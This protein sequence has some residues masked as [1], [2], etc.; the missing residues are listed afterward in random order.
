MRSKRG[1]SS[2][3]VLLL[4]AVAA[5]V[6]IACFS[7]L[8]VQYTPSALTRN[9]VVSFVYPEASARVVEAEVTSVIEGALSNIQY[10]KGVES[11]SR[12]G[13]GQII[14]RIGKKANME[15]V[16][17]DVAS[18]IRN[19]WTSL[20]STCTYPIV[21]TDS[22]SGNTSGSVM[23]LT[24]KSPLP[25]LQIA[26]FIQGTLIYPLSSIEGVDDVS[27]Y[28]DTPYEWVI[29]FDADKTQ[30]ADIS[31]VEISSA[32]SSYYG[33]VLVGMVSNGG[34]SFAVKLTEHTSDDFSAIPVKKV[35]GRIIHLGDIAQ[36]HYQESLPQS[37]YR[38]NGL[39]TL[40]LTVG[41]ASDANILS[42][43]SK[44]RDRLQELQ[45]AIPEEISIDISYDYSEYIS[46]ELNKIYQRTALCLLILLA[47]VFLA[48]RSWRYM[49]VIA[50]TLA[51][52]IFISVA[53]YFFAG[54][55]IHIYTLAGITVSL[56]IIIDNSI[57]M[58]DHYLRRRNR[59]V[60]PA[61]LSA[62]LTTV[63]ALLVVLLL[64]EEEK[65]NLVDFSYVIIINLVVSLMVSYLFVPALLDYVSV[66]PEDFDIIPVKRKKRVIFLNSVYEKYIRWGMQ[67]RWL[68]VVLFIIVFGIPTCLIPKDVA[69]KWQV[70]ARDRQT[71]D[72]SIGGTF[73]LFNRA[74]SRS[75]FYREPGRP[76]IVVEAGMPEGCSVQQ[77]NDVIKHMENYLSQFDEIE[78]FSTEIPSYSRGTITILFKPEYEK[79]GIPY[80]LKSRIISIA[81]DFGGANWTVYGLDNNGFSN[82]VNTDRR[83][84]GIQLTGYNL[85]DLIK[86]GE[87][88][89]AFLGRNR[90]VS[91]CEIWG[92]SSRY[93]PKTEFSILY[94]FENMALKELSPSAY[95][96]TLYSPLYAN[97]V[98]QL[99][100]DGHYVPVRLESSV[101]DSFDVWN[102][103]NTAISVGDTKA[104]LSEIGT[105]DK[106]RTGFPISKINQSYVITVAYNFVGTYKQSQKVIDDALEYMNKSVLPVGYK[107]ENE[108]YS[109]FQEKRSKYTSLIL[110]VIAAIFVICATQFN[111]LKYS[112]S[113]IWLIPISFIGPFLIF[114]LSDFTFDKGGFAAFV[115][116]SGITVNAGIHL[117]SSWIQT[118]TSGAD[119]RRF[120]KSFNY[121]IR[122][123]TLTILSTMLG[124]IPFLFDG[125]SEVFWFDFAVG[126]ISGL[127]FSV[128]AFVF[129]LP[130]F[131]CS[132][133]KDN[134]LD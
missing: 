19:I 126:T 119:C 31:A 108:N 109:Y 58:I 87:Q 133:L 49:L 100:Q 40:M 75:D 44:V 26:D 12:D 110:L 97:S 50:V 90:R 80:G 76:Q 59:S 10:C 114:G 91:D 71:I 95:F 64:P 112:S 30:S 128:I 43:C 79:S 131:C 24:I 123:I 63:A 2:F 113:I 3:S 61:L 125:P 130:V 74:L 121:K 20:P 22:Q 11:L 93:R 39:N 101:K 4:M 41:A 29:T 45:S 38:I 94:D 37:Y 132:Q 103:G 102:V 8:K 127:F 28:G 33:E 35:N 85:D 92:G 77:L 13:S 96:T 55:H 42:V 67:H 53:L 105:I 46:S 52:N 111:S 7:Q 56:G 5:V 15:S 18:R 1:I 82:Y 124:L 60:F 27:F 66:H 115:M 57:V 81:S 73:A 17:F 69:A 106:K 72:K 32:I 16:R 51:V 120:V 14:L 54:L 104:K 98:I 21:A 6:G 118:N 65:Q 9:I 134:D 62:V 23:S 88:L 86:Y 36:A 99:L 116:L 47:F 84:Y 68:Y 25:S 107:A 70:Y 34:N 48:N 117:V 129:I 89:E 78:V 83:N 122:P